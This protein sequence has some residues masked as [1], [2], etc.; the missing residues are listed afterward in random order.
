[1]IKFVKNQD[2]MKLRNKTW[3]QYLTEYNVDF[4][5]KND[6]FI[7]MAQTYDHLPFLVLLRFLESVL[8]GQYKRQRTIIK[9]FVKDF[10]T[11]ENRKII[12]EYYH[13]AGD[14]INLEKSINYELT[15]NCIELQEWAK[16]YELILKLRT[17]KIK[18]EEITQEAML[19]HAETPEMKV[20]AAIIHLYGI[21]Q[22]R[23]FDPLFKVSAEVIK[24]VEKMDN[25]YLRQSFRLIILEMHSYANLLTNNVQ[26]ARAIAFKACSEDGVEYFPMTLSILQHIIGL[27]Y[28]F[29]S[30]D[31]STYW[32][33]KAR[34]ILFHVQSI[35]ADEK[36]ISLNH[37]LAFIRSFWGKDLDIEPPSIAEKAHRCLVLQKKEE[38]KKLIEQLNRQEGG[39][40]AFQYYFYA[41]AT[42]NS[43]YLELS[44]ELFEKEGN[45]F[46]L[47]LFKPQYLEKYIKGKGE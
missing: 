21:N 36:L 22:I 29:E 10:P 11:L 24:L 5:E 25:P 39:L 12:M 38:A 20:L 6:P 30:F 15:S 45:Q 47:Q 40:T 43:Y 23:L 41:A 37:S 32:L 7:S 44:K 28:L 1:M 3:K 16:M 13:T 4:P 17:R 33:N 9:A 14:F 35:R 26:E 27:S 8:P 31:E 46:Y 18:G 34:K 19:I 42:G 2:V